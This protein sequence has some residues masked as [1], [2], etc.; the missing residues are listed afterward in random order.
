ME[1]RL[2]GDIQARLDGQE[3]DVGHIKQR[4]VLATLLT[5]ANRVVPVEQLIDRVWAD[6]P[7]LRARETLYGY[8]YR[9]RRALSAA[10]DVK[11][12]STPG[13]YVLSVDVMAV[14]LHRFRHLVTQARTA[15]SDE[16]SL[17]LFDQALGLSSGDAFANLDS[18]WVNAMRDVLEKQRFA[19]ILE[20]TDLAL[21]SGR[22]SE[23]LSELFARVAAHPLDERS[24]GQLMLAL[25]R[26]GRRTVALDQYQQVRQHLAEE[27]GVDPGP[28]LQV[29]HQ[30]ILRNDPMLDTASTVDSDIGGALRYTAQAAPMAVVPRQ[31][32]I[33]PAGFVGRVS[34]LAQLDKIALKAGGATVISVIS[35]GGGVGKTW[36]AL[37]WAHR[38]V[39]RFPDGQL[40]VDLRGFAPSGQPLSPEVAVRGLLNALGVDTRSIS[41]DLDALAGL[42]RSLVAGRRMLILLDN[43][44]E[45]SQVVPLL[46]GS[47]TCTV[48]V[49]SR[50]LLTG[51]VTAYSAQLLELD[52]LTETDARDLLARDIGAER[53]AAEPDAVNELLDYCGGLALALGIVAARATI[54]PD[55][56]LAAVAGELRD[57]TSRLDALNGGELAVN[58]RAVLSWS[59][60]SLTHQA[61]EVFALLGLA[62][63]PDI[64]LAAAASLTALPAPQT[65]SVLRELE[66]AHLIHRHSTDR[67]R[68]H[69]L[70]RLHAHEQAHNNLPE[71]TRTTALHRLV[72]YYLHTACA[73]DRLLAPHRSPIRLDPHTPGTHPH[74]L[75]DRPAAMAWFDSEHANLLAAQHAAAT[76]QWHHTVWQMAWALNTFQ[77]RQG[78]LHDQLVVW[79]AALD[80]AV[81]LP[82]PTTHTSTHRYLGIAHADLR[83]HEE[84]IE[85][86]HQALALAEHHHPTHQVLTH[87]T[88][89]WAWKQRGDDQRA[90][91]HAR[92][93]LELVRTLDQP[94]QEA[95]ALNA[96][97]WYAAQLGDYD[98]ARSHCQ[99]A[100]TLYHHHHDPDGE[101]TAL[102]SLGY[103]EH[104]TGY[105]HRAIGHY[106]QALNLYRDLGHTPRMAD[107][108]TGL[109]H[110]HAA[111][112]HHDHARAA[113][114]HALDL[115]QKQ[116][117][118]TDA[119]RVRQHLTT[120][121]TRSF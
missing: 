78:L 56:P 34:E 114:E 69:D 118:T 20:R 5:D 37:N 72:D 35:G 32:P 106:Q 42:Y 82:D 48:L 65:L 84:A 112:G 54:Q 27:V 31:L 83:R 19:A 29:L 53:L 10:D 86:L 38:N 21:R 104:H 110:P 74:P 9:L 108:L 62:P 101:A 50:R 44:R 87:L 96:V 13:G 94:V 46:P 45:T 85:H 81:H 68:M 100:L 88:L 14:D 60:H 71:A 15:S 36:L 2:L 116:L 24:A 67:Y 95:R 98:T 52:V 120:L 41:A 75:P 63:G 80:A 40:Y 22:H 4:G 109:G 66:H 97:G 92:L 73:A 18:P 17:V 3:V 93:A 25:Y 30:R 107:T 121:D 26:S 23:L 51:L 99:A 102:D 47:P 119:E 43:A 16:Q 115:Y 103:I 117:R 90:L 39:D 49:T 105:H 28:A 64:R 59:Q 111:L 113:W 89:S 77:Y 57:R 7:P 1:F 79:Q 6:H 11:I 58:L 76:Q 70:I 12:S 91:D 33:A 55:V 8:L 61:T